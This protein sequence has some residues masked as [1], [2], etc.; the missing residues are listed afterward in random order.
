MA[1]REVAPIGG[2]EAF[3]SVGRDAELSQAAIVLSAGAAVGGRADRIDRPE[4]LGLPRE[5]RRISVERTLPVAEAVQPLDL[6]VRTHVA[7]RALR[8][9]AST[10]AELT[11]RLID[12]PDAFTAAALVE[13]NLHSDSRLVRTAAA[14]AALDTTGPRDDVLDRLVEGARSRDSLA[15]EIGRI[16]VARVAPQHPVLRRMVVQPGPQPD[17]AATPAGNVAVLTHGTFAANTLWWRPGGSLYRYLDALTPPLH[18]HDPSFQ[19]SGQYSDGARQLAAQQ[20][21]DWIAG[22]GLHTPALFA[23]SHGGTVG[24][25]ATKR[26]QV[27]DR[28]VLMSWPVHAEWFPDF[29]KVRMVVDIRVRFDL[30][31]MADRGGQTFK[32]PAAF[33]SKVVSHIN[34]WFNHGDT[35]DPA[36][37]D[38]YRL[39]AAI[40]V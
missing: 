25:L 8:L 19:W 11:R 24:N 35:N 23:H 32:P 5:L 16:G 21:V 20:L 27:I 7:D 33:R 31:V 3:Q 30:V 28:L 29:T 12:R 14:V 38:R 18:L 1:Y 6:D 22:F 36:Y 4:A 10:S 34:G 26:G 40:Q 13:A 37:W 15:R 39:P 17:Q 2:P 9:P